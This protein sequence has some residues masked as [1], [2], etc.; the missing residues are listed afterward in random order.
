MYYRLP[1]K[2]MGVW[3]IIFPVGRPDIITLFG[4]NDSQVNGLPVTGFERCSTST[5]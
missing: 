5:K 4:S 1:V 3:T 2:L